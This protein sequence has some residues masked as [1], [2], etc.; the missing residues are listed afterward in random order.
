MIEKIDYDDLTGLAR[1]P[2]CYDTMVTWNWLH[3]DD[4]R[5]HHDCS[6]CGNG[7]FTLEKVEQVAPK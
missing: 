3:G 2:H 7:F 6:D 5:W 1:C 4:G